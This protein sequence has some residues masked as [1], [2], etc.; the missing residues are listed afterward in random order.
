MTDKI[1]EIIKEAQSIMQNLFEVEYYGANDVE[2]EKNKIKRQKKDKNGDIVDVVS[3]E[4]ELFPYEGNA[5]QQYN[6]KIIFHG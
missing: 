3:V 6:Q 4:D 2:E 5:K 1:T